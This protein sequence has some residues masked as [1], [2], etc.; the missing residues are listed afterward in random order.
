MICQNCGKEHDGTY[1]SGKFC[2]RACANAREFSQE[3]KNLKS[4]KQKEVI[5]KIG[6]SD[7][8]LNHIGHEFSEFERSQ[9]ASKGS[10][11]QRKK[12]EVWQNKV[13]EEGA[14][15]EEVR[16][17][18]TSLRKRLIEEVGH[19]EIC[20]QLPI[21]NGKPLSLQVDH[22][23]GNLDNNKKENLRV[24]CLHCHSQ[25]PYYGSKNKG[26][27]RLLRSKNSVKS[28]D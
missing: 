25:T 27:G 15:W 14:P 9:G 2:C 21:W 11:T 18:W 7:A 16:S 13:L 22:I 6:L 4:Q 26:R 12:A 19:C 24:V 17:R 10:E 28:T 3:T 5:E 23:D 1:G 8:F 20:G